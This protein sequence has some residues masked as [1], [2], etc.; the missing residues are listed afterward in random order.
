[1]TY[2][3]DLPRSP[4]PG[5]L[6]L[7]CIAGQGAAVQDAVDG[8]DP[9]MEATFVLSVRASLA[10]AWAPWRAAAQLRCLA[11]RHWP[12][13]GYAWL[14]TKAGSSAPRSPSPQAMSVTGHR[15]ASGPCVG[16]RRARENSIRLFVDG[17]G[18][19]K[20][21]STLCLRRKIHTEYV[22]QLLDAFGAGPLPAATVDRD[23]P[24]TAGIPAAE[25]GLIIEALS[26]REVEVLR[27]HGRR[28][29][30]GRDRHRLGIATSTV[31]SHVRHLPQAERHAP[32]AGRRPRPHPPT[33]QQAAY[34]A[35]PHRPYFVPFVCFCALAAGSGKLLLMLRL[36]GCR[37]LNYPPFHPGVDDAHR[38]AAM[39]G[40]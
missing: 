24:C 30:N 20:L 3:T 39:L 13:A 26:D 29:P 23:G 17:E 7:E 12:A 33:R 31:K 4:W 11:A 40:E 35:D 10:G 34:S 5:W 14:P 1:M 8:D 27:P 36:R 32:H 2:P 18:C 6:T 15:C 25:D 16:H 22:A 38:R 21:V 19:I 28:P 9:A 37:R